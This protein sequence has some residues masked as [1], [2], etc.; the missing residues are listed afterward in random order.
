MFGLGRKVRM[1]P[2][3]EWL[4]GR[5]PD[6]T[7]QLLEVKRETAKDSSEYLEHLILLSVQCCSASFKKSVGGWLLQRFNRAASDV[8]AFE[9]LVFCV[10]AVRESHLLTPEHPLDES[11]PESVVEA[12]R[13]AIAAL[14]HFVSRFTGWEIADIWQRRI[15]FYFQ[16][17]S[18]KEATEAFVGILLTMENTSRPAREYGKLSL[19]RSLNLELR[20]RVHAFASTIPAATADVIQSVITEYNLDW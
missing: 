6:R 15:L 17:G 10:Y 2:F 20:V 18:M 12:Y 11:D 8:I 5:T 13:F 9:A 16:C 14:P 19:D 7:A 3:W 1:G 4:E